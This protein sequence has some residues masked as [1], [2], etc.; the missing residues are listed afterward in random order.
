[1]DR[2]EKGE[3]KKHTLLPVD[4]DDGFLIKGSVGGCLITGSI[5]GRSAGRPSKAEA[6]IPLGASTLEL[7]I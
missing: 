6:A 2:K 1:M 4:C 3:T 5:G 7:K